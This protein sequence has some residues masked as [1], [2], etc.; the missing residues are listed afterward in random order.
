M[1]FDPD[2]ISAMR[3]MIVSETKEERLKHLETLAKFQREDIAGILK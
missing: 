2:R 3:A 1:F